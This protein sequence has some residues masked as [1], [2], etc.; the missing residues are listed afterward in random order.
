MTASSGYNNFWKAFHHKSVTDLMNIREIHVLVLG[1][2]W[3]NF[4]VS[5]CRSYLN[6]RK[7]N[8]LITALPSQ[9][10]RMNFSGLS[11]TTA[12]VALVTTRNICTKKKRNKTD[13]NKEKILVEPE[14]W[15][16]NSY[17][18]HIVG[19]CSRTFTYTV[20]TKRAVARICRR[21]LQQCWT[22]WK[23]KRSSLSIF[24]LDFSLPNF[25]P[26]LLFWVFF[27]TSHVLC[28]ILIQRKTWI[29]FFSGSLFT[30]MYG[31]WLEDHLLCPQYLFC[32]ISFV[33]RK[34]RGQLFSKQ[35]SLKQQWI[36]CRVE[37]TKINCLFSKH[38]VI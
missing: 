19:F 22:L 27:V 34:T 21:F 32:S 8:V 38:V 12:S 26:H 6:G 33:A 31:H 23:Q 29:P 2:D 7:R 24:N 4:R 25:F 14:R 17:S 9:R 10:S 16:W 30:K 36:W 1:R 15:L 3:N 11:L 20:Q 13:K 35:W 37:D 18:F 5:D 28:Y